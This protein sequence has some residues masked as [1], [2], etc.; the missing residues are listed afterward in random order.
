MQAVSLWT[1]WFVISIISLSTECYHGNLR[2]VFVSERN[3][4]KIHQVNESFLYFLTSHILCCAVGW[5]LDQ[6]RSSHL[7]WLD[8]F[9][10]KDLLSEIEQYLYYTL[11]GCKS[12]ECHCSMINY[13]FRV[14]VRI[15]GSFWLS[16]GLTYVFRSGRISWKSRALIV[17]YSQKKEQLLFWESFNCS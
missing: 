13:T 1:L 9:L 14:V 2:Q 5:Q 17:R 8:K 16:Y 3:T 7:S 4:S 6:E 12:G 10:A 15:I 11:I